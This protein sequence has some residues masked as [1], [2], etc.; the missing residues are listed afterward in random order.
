[1]SKWGWSAFACLSIVI[2]G[3]LTTA[4]ASVIA[5]AMLL[6]L[7][8]MRRADPVAVAL[9]AVLMTLGMAAL[10]GFM[11]TADAAGIAELF[12][13]DNMGTMTGR[14]PLW[15]AL[16]D[17]SKNDPFGSGFGAA[18]RFVP[19]LIEGRYWIGWTAGHT[20]NG[21]IS[22][23]LGVGF[24]GFLLSICMV[25]SI[26]SATARMVITDRV[27]VVPLIILMIIQN[28]SG[29]AFGGQFNPAWMII[30]AMTCGPSP[31]RCMKDVILLPEPR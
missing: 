18:D 21:F 31:G 11:L 7:W 9:A 12:G 24:P 28:M 2:F 20:H 27:L 15:S 4:A 14:L 8:M 30:M 22:A 10:G 5:L 1:M 19:A 29:P 6:V 16:W 13:K 25:L 17:F 26:L 3:S 23:W